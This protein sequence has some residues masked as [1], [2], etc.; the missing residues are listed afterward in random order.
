MPASDWADLCPHTIGWTPLT[1]RDQYGKP[2]YGPEQTFQGRRVYKIER[3]PS[4]GQ[5]DGAVV[6]SSSTIWILGT[7]AVGYD[8][9]VYVVGDAKFP[10]VLNVMRY[11]DEA[12]ELFVKVQLGS[13]K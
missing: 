9:K 6:L 2:T 1:G 5:G 4:G 3:V 10:P 11:P 7:P 8:D 13:A 12:A